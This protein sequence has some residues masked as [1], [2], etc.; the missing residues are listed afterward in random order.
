MNGARPQITVAHKGTNGCDIA[1]ISTRHLR[2]MPS[3][4]MDG[5]AEICF[6]DA[7]VV[8]DCC[9]LCGVPYRGLAHGIKQLRIIANE[10]SYKFIAL[11]AV[12]ALIPGFQC[13]P[14]PGVSDDPRL[15]VAILCR[16]SERAFIR[17]KS[18]IVTDETLDRDMGIVL[19]H[20]HQ[21]KTQ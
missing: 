3:D 5:P 13:K 20:E 10:F 18:P 15:V 12:A 6:G 2:G 7:F 9:K 17:G 14:K 16:C 4:C 19:L 11:P 8:R 1:L 21:E